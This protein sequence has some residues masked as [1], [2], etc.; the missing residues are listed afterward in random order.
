VASAT[1]IHGRRVVTGLN[2]AGI[3][4]EVLTD[5]PV[6]PGRL[7]GTLLNVLFASVG[8]VVIRML[9]APVR[10]KLLTSLLS[11]EDYGLLTLVMLT[12]S[13]VTLIV[14]LGS[15]EFMLRK[16]PGQTPSYQLKTLRTVATYFGMIAAGV[17]LLGVGLL[18]M[19]QPAKLG[20]TAADT[21]ACGLI[22]LLTVHITQLA[23]YLLGRS[24]YAQSRLLTL[25][26]ADVWFLPLLGL[27]WVMKITVSFMLWFWVAWL[28]LSLVL[29]QVFVRSRT[30]LRQRPSRDLFRDVL[31]FGVPLMPMIMGEWIFQVQDRY[32]LL[33]FTDLAAVANYTLCFNIAWVGVATGASLMDI[34]VTE[35]YKAR[36]L[37]R[38]DALDDLLADVPLRKAFTMM[39]RYSLALSLP[40]VLALWIAR[41]P[42]LILLSDPKFADAADLLRW[43][44]PL[45]LLYLMVIIAGRTLMAMDRG[46][47]VGMATLCAAGLH[48]LLNIMLAPVLAERGAALAGCIAYGALAIYLGIRAR[49]FRWI[50][51]QELRPLRLLV[52]TVVTGVGLYGSVRLLD[53]WN[54][55]MLLS[56]GII[57]LSAMLGLGAIRI[58]DMHRIIASIH[59]P[60]VGEDTSPRKPADQ[61]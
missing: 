20:M 19:W 15:L 7:G 42:I 44:A 43:V 4:G 32:V 54:F 33:T 9:I 36:N 58:S 46:A 12:I 55:L 28:L 17:G 37:V 18:V 38:S 30:L 45:P 2:A 6:S 40:I 13:F 11:K 52:F 48:L 60:P 57:S 35:F 1:T 24:A 21:V 25:F 51:W 16:L 34:L 10:I 23:Y 26:H 41:Q 27:M 56:G 61:G 31:R 5:P 50:D 22:L 47:I 39:L 8:Y 53:G 14:S 49:L 29:S 3:E 59:A